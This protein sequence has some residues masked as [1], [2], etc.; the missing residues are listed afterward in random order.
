MIVYIGMRSSPNTADVAVRVS[1]AL[2]PL[3]LINMN[4]S[5][6]VGNN[7]GR[8]QGGMWGMDSPHQPFSTMLWMNEIFPQCR[9][10]S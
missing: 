3:F 4:E 1:R 2:R 9:T 10:S 5:R 7:Q 6:Q 8:I